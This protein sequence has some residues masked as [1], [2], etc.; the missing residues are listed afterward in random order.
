[1]KIA[2]SLIALIGNTPLLSMERLSSSEGLENAVIAKLEYFNPLSSSKD[3]VADEMLREGYAKGEIDSDTVIIEPTSGNT[4]IGLAFV[5]RL[6][7]N[8][9]IFTLPESMSIERIKLLKYLGAEIVLTPAAEGMSGAIKKAQALKDALPNAC[10]PGQFVNPANPAAH[11]KTTG[12]EIWRD[13]DGTV[14]CFVAG[15]GTGG[16]VTGTARYLKNRNPRVHIVGVE[17][18]LSPVLSRGQ[19]GTHGIQ[20]IG[21]GFIPDTLDLSLIDA[22]Q[23]VTD[24][25]AMDYARKA[26][27]YEGLPVGISSGA[28]LCASVKIAKTKKFSNIVVLLPDSAERY[29]STS[30]FDV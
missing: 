8:R 19:P 4:G 1:M 25:E 21:A 23:T 28:A 6:Y 9:V 30:L 24:E 16:T 2:S 15:I 5:A 22:I 17:P 7:G 14:D 26:A 29:I 12:P 13:T 27:R 11:E 3:R 18:A 20:G 10:I